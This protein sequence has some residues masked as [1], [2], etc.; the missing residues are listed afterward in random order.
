[1]PRQLVQHVIEKA[2]TGLIVIDARA[3]DG[4]FDGEMNGPIFIQTLVAKTMAVVSKVA[5]ENITGLGSGLTGEYELGDG[6][7]NDDVEEDAQPD[8]GLI[9]KVWD[10]YGNPIVDI[11]GRHMNATETVTVEIAME[12]QQ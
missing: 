7:P 6:L 11:L 4:D 8:D 5:A 10:S 3:V 2:D 9:E 12:Q 1:M